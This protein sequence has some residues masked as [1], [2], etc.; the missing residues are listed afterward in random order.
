MIAA[1]PNDVIT[2][3]GSLPVSTEHDAGGEARVSHSG[4][5]MGGGA[6]PSLQ[7]NFVDSPHVMGCPPL[8]APYLFTYAPHHT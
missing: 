7:P 6:P 2:N 8:G 3:D 4:K 5:S 1:I